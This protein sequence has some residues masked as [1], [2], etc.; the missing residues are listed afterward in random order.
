MIQDQIGSNRIHMDVM[1]ILHFRCPVVQ[2]QSVELWSKRWNLAMKWP[3]LVLDSGEPS[4]PRS[5]M[6][7]LD[8]STCSGNPCRFTDRRAWVFYDTFRQKRKESS[9]VYL[10]IHPIW[11]SLI[12]S[13]IREDLSGVS[14]W[15]ILSVYLWISSIYGPSRW[16]A[17]SGAQLPM[18]WSVRCLTSGAR[19]GDLSAY[20]HFC[21]GKW[22][23]KS[24][25][26]WN[27]TI[28]RGTRNLGRGRIQIWVFFSLHCIWQPFW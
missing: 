10:S 8:Q 24:C 19:T 2:W 1:M 27:S 4:A 3:H 6:T 23:F 15:Y 17:A 25:F 9:C 22:T 26:F 13:G 12:L 5:E 16:S 20:G 28:F 21:W 14:I 7:I 11:S 18:Q